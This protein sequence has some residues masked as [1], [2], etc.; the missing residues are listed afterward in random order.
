MQILCASGALMSIYTLG[1][2]ISRAK[3]LVYA[4]LLRNS[5][6]AVIVVAGSFLGVPFG[7]EGVAVACAASALA[8]FIMVMQL[9]KEIVDGS[10]HDI[11]KA[12]LP[13]VLMGALI[14]AVSSLV[15]VVAGLHNLPALPV[16]LA[17]SVGFIS[18]YFAALAF[19]PARL[20][21]DIPE[22][23]LNQCSSFLPPWF[24]DMLSKRWQM[25]VAGQVRS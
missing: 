20:H 22:F 6:H 4:K 3:G 23:V 11:F 14:A 7:I 5:I 24:V 9:G 2:T 21:G 16:L 19:L 8:M 18:T 25:P 12:H 15:L 13:G 17:L 1:D 10:W